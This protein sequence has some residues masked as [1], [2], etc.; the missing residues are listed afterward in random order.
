MF[1]GNRE[2]TRGV[3][4]LNTVATSLNLWDYTVDVCEPV[5]ADHSA[6]LRSVILDTVSS[7]ATF[8]P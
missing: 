5:I 3:H 8:L 6:V 4:Y 7:I 1:I 2:P